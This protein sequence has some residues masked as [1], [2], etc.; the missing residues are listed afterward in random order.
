[1]PEGAFKQRPQLRHSESAASIR[2]AVAESH[3]A[4]LRSVA[5]F[6]IRKER[7]LTWP[8]ALD[9]AGEILNEA[10]EQ[11]LKQADSFDPT[12]SAAAWIRG[13]A[14][15]LLLG[16]GRLQARERRCISA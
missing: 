11:A 12:R 6:V 15:R 2:K 16:R 1:M 8:A 4:L 13:I 10:V 7:G 14:A 3:K 5:L 9:E